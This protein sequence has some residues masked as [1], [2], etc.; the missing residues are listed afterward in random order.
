MR[1]MFKRRDLEH[2]SCSDAKEAATSTIYWG[3]FR[4]G[5][6]NEPRRSVICRTIT[7]INGNLGCSVGFINQTLYA[8]AATAFR[9]IVGPPGQA[10][11]CLLGI[12]GYPAEGLGGVH[13]FGQ[14]AW[15]SVTSRPQGGAAENQRSG[16]CRGLTSLPDDPIPRSDPPVG[17][18][19]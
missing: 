13:A 6:R 8:L 1:L 17:P 18:F 4:T 3:P 16:T 10:D 7:R 12:T 5:G 11:N 2:P 9:D 15:Q 14:R 19:R